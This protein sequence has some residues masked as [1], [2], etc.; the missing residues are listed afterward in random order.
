MPRARHWLRA[1]VVL[2]FVIAPSTGRT[3]ERAAQ[4]DRLPVIRNIGGDFTLTGPR[5]ERV[6][7]HDFRG[8]VILLFFGYT[9]CPDVCPTTLLTLR[10]VMDRLQSDAAQVQVVMITVDPQRDTPTRLNSFVKYFDQSFVGLTGAPEEIAATA[11]RY[12]VHYEK[13][14]A[15]AGYSVA[16]GAFVYLIDGQ[17]RLRAVYDTRTGPPRIASD[18]RR[19][20]GD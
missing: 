20:L 1:V 2:P 14:P 15:D 11:R 10:Q 13:E 6:R 12:L 3:D 19:L 5:G 17:G 8:R 7:L 18:V 9:R 4:P 16:H